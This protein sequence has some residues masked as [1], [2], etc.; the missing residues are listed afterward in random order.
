VLSPQLRFHHVCCASALPRCLKPP[1][2]EDQTPSA[3]C[4]SINRREYPGAFS[5]LR[6]R[7]RCKLL[8]A[9]PW[10]DVRVTLCRQ[11]MRIHLQADGRNHPVCTSHVRLLQISNF[12]IDLKRSQKSHQ[13]TG[14]EDCC[15]NVVVPLP[16]SHEVD[17]RPFRLPL[18]A[19]PLRTRIGH[20]Q[21]RGIFSRSS[22]L[23]SPDTQRTVCPSQECQGMQ[24]P[25]SRGHR[26]R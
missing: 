21:R 7:D 25:R 3:L 16:P 5:V 17:R 14:D 10:K 26:R 23:L 22:N 13:H 15:S 2:C 19:P 1:P 4:D 12:H 20:R 18:N 24:D 6:T 11:A 9:R 8:R